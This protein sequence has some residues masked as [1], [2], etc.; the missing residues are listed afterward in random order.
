MYWGTN[1][2]SVSFEENGTCDVRVFVL[3]QYRKQANTGTCA[4]PRCVLTCHCDMHMHVGLKRVVVG[5]VMAN[6][7]VIYEEGENDDSI[8]PC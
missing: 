8:W 1:R 6:S 2:G 4:Y 5:R 3:L 7:S